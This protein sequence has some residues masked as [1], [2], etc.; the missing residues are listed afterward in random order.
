MRT[1]L[2]ALHRMVYENQHGS[3]SSTYGIDDILNKLRDGGEVTVKEVRGV[4]EWV[5]GLVD[6]FGKVEHSS[7]WAVSHA[8]M[9]A[10]IG[11]A[12]EVLVRMHEA[13]VDEVDT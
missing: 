2:Y 8:L 13:M 9:M 12:R 1:Q 10:V 6:G 4:I 11:Q 5:R 3:S 7:E